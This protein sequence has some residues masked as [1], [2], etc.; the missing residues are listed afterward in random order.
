MTDRTSSNVPDRFG[1]RTFLKRAAAPT[2]VAAALRGASAPSNQ[3]NVAVIGLGSQ[4]RRDLSA[5]LGVNARIVAI[6][7]VDTRQF[8]RVRRMP[9]MEH[10][11]GYT[12]YRALLEKA[13]HVDGVVVATPDHW[14]ALICA[15]ALSAGKHVY[16]EKPLARTVGEARMLREMAAVT[17]VTTQ[18]GNQGSA[19]DAFRRSVEAIEA[20][21]LGQIQ[22]V[23]A[24]IPGGKFPRGVNRPGGAGN[25]TPK[26]LNWDFWLGPAPEQPYYD[27]LFHPFDWRG[28]YAFG[29]GQLG[30]FGCHAFNLPFRALKL[31]YPYRI[32]VAGTGFGKDSYF[33]NGRVD[34]YFGPREGLSPVVL[35]WYDEVAPPAE[36]FRDVIAAFGDLPSGVLLLGDNG[37]LFTS[38][39]N[40]E[41]RI[42]LKGDTQFQSVLRHPAL[43]DVPRRLSRIQ[44]HHGEWV[45]AAKRG[46]QSYSPFE[47]GGHLTEIVQAGVLALQ[48]ARGIAWSG[49]AMQAAGVPEAEELIRPRYRPRWMA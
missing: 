35:S 30:D 41:G 45:F 39:H 8:A 27:H 7:D 10:V 23:Y 43:R 29:S 26:G 46:A 15:A 6:C 36:P 34:F 24:Y 25:G 18:M 22:Q 5:L 2:V 37:Q 33:L 4:G 28:W 3:F 38:P 48:L 16:C 20:G 14:H 32:D 44:S 49:E 12:D 31:D 17:R 42:K 9:G 47:Q 19:S 21:A 1:R 11:R 40:T 13:P